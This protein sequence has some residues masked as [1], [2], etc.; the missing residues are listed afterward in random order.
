[1][2]SPIGGKTT[3]PM[4]STGVMPLNRRRSSSTGCGNL[5][6]LLTHRIVSIFLSPPSQPSPSQ[7]SPSWEGEGWEGGE[8]KMDTILC[9]NNLSRFPQPVELDLRRF[10]GITPVECMGGVV[11]PP[12]GE[13]IYLLTLPGHGFYW[14]QLPPLAQARLSATR[15]RRRL[16]Y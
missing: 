12:I 2:S 9:V 1:M 4:H 15:D 7:S 14:F 16:L 13:L 10:K 8:R 3:P 11:F 5:D 6:R